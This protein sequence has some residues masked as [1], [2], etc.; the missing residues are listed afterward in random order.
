MLPWSPVLTHNTNGKLAV[1]LSPS[2]RDIVTVTFS[3]TNGTGVTEVSAP[4]RPACCAWTRSVPLNT[5]TDTNTI[6][7]VNLV[8]TFILSPLSHQRDE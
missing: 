2:K 8:D 4:A 7:A 5:S 6:P 3:G 1:F